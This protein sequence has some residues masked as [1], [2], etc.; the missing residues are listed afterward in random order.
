[1]IVRWLRFFSHWMIK[2]MI[3]YAT[4]RVAI[5]EHIAMHIIILYPFNCEFLNDLWFLSLNKVVDIKRCV[6]I[7]FLQ[8]YNMIYSKK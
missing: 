7:V 4:M 1:M 6:Y 8:H 5:K 3:T 2:V